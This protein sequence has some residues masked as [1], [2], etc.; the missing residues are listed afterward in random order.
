VRS[1]ATLQLAFPTPLDGFFGVFVHR[2]PDEPALPN[3]GLSVEYSVVGLSVE[4]SVVASV[5]S[6]MALFDDLYTLHH[7]HAPSQQAIGTYPIEV[8][9]VPK[10]MS[11]F[12]L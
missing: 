1:D 12:S 4:Y 8:R 7:R 11:A 9:V 10:V 6:C 3:L 5:W 2:W